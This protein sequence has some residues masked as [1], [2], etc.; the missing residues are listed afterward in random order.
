MDHCPSQPCSRWHEDVERIIPGVEAA[1]NVGMV[2]EWDKLIVGAALEVPIAFAQVHVNLDGVSDCWHRGCCCCM[3]NGTCATA[4]LARA[5][6]ISCGAS[7]LL[8]TPR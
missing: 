2:N 1:C 5:Y 4:P 7:P 3:T 8:I 6:W